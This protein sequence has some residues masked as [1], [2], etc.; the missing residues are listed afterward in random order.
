MDKPKRKEKSRSKAVVEFVSPYTVEECIGIL[1]A[2]A[3][4]GM[5][6]D[7]F[8]TTIEVFIIDSDQY[9]FRVER[10]QRQGATTY[11]AKGNLKRWYENTTFV[12]CEAENDE[13][14]SPG[15]FLIMLFIIMAFIA[16]PAYWLHILIIG[17]IFLMLAWGNSRTEPKNLLYYVRDLLDPEDKSDRLLSGYE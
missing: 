2:H 9:E 1:Q 3:K 16:N 14:G 4:D 10:K 15:I 7:Q 8:K 11:N 5:L 12:T 13:V 17:G 6:F